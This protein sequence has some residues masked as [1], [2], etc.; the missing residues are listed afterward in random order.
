MS[1]YMS[2]ASL[3]TM[4]LLFPL[5]HACCG[6]GP[7]AFEPVANSQVRTRLDAVPEV[8]RSSITQLSNNTDQW[9]LPATRTYV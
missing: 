4:W 1:C 9:A 2:R 6:S 5:C 3:V 8:W 7:P